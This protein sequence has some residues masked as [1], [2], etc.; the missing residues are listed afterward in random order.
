MKGFTL[1]EALVALC[2]ATVITTVMWMI[3]STNIS[4]GKKTTGKLDGLKGSIAFTQRFEHDLYRLYMSE[5][6]PLTIE[7]TGDKKITFFIFSEK[8]STLQNANIIVHKITYYFSK[9][10]H[11]IYRQLDGEKKKRLRGY[12]EDLIIERQDSPGSMVTYLVTS[13]SPD[14]FQKPTQK[15]KA[16]D[17]TVF[18]SS[19]ALNQLQSMQFQPNWNPITVNVQEKE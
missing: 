1:I 12:Y 13:V 2:L 18:Q 16:F 5:K 6:F 11:A 14:F 9:A 10:K 17:R 15:Q 7:D 3:F 4:Q 19:I 8:F